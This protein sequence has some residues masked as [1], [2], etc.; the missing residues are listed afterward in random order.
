M[1][2]DFNKKYKE[3]N[4][5]GNIPTH[6]KYIY[7]YEC[8]NDLEEIISLIAYDDDRDTSDYITYI[9][10]QNERVIA[11]NIVPLTICYRPKGQI[12]G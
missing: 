4:M 5:T 9:N 10:N 6:P 11:S 2:T 8:P 7:E 3:L 12:D 1:E